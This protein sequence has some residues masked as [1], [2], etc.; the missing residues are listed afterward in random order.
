MNGMIKVKME[1][2]SVLEGHSP[3]K[4]VKAMS[5]G[6]WWF[7][8]LKNYMADV[9]E[10]CRNWNE[11]DPEVRT[12]SYSQ[13]ILDLENVRMLTILEGKDVLQGCLTS[14]IAKG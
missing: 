9:A 6:Y 10:N 13:F 11:N 3:E 4:I 5:A 14:E 8:T 2:G 7:T 1:D 12:D